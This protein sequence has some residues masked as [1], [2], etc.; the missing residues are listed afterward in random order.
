[1]KTKTEN[2]HF[3]YI[4]E[5]RD[6]TLYTGW[7]TDL[8]VR[9]SA[10]NDGAAGAKYTRTRRPVRLVYFEEF[11]DKGAALKRERAIKKLTRRQKLSLIETASGNTGD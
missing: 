2:K 8:T 5:C 3:V 10:H 11:E 4:L 6:H 7:T 1:M 9:L